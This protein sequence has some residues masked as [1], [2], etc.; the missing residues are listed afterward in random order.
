[1]FS[2]FRNTAVSL[3]AAA[4]ALAQFASPVQ[5]AY[6]VTLL[7]VPAGGG[8]TNVVATGSGSIDLTDMSLFSTGNT[9]AATIF[10]GIGV[11]ITGPAATEALDEYTG[12]TGPTSFGGFNVTDADSGSGDIV[13]LDNA[14]GPNPTLYV[15]AGYVSGHALSDSATYDNATFASL[16]ATPGTYTWHWGTGAHADSFTLQIGPV[17]T[18]PEPASL[19][20]LAMGLVGLG[21]VLR[22]RRA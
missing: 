13:G 1:M 22:T 11:I 21:M 7:E 15:P 19:T 5:A 4:L 6:V 20:L 10:P 9:F 16:A 2:T 14:Q 18:A 8:I 3:G 12:Y 17:A